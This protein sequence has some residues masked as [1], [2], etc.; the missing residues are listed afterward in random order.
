[1]RIT[2][3]LQWVTTVLCAGAA[4]ALPCHAQRVTPQDVIRA[5][6]AENVAPRS[7]K[8]Y[9]ESLVNRLDPGDDPKIIL[10]VIELQLRA[11]IDLGL[12]DKL[13]HLID[14]ASKLSAITGDAMRAASLEA[15]FARAQFYTGHDIAGVESSASALARQ[16]AIVVDGKH[17]DPTRLFRQ[18]I[19]HAQLIASVMRV[20]TLVT[21]LK[22]AEKLMPAVRNPALASIDHDNLLAQV[23]F[24]L[25]DLGRVR[26][27]LAS[28]LERAKRLEVLTWE[29]EVHFLMAETYIAQAMPA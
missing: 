2:S 24:A 13:Q 6:A 7:Q 9:A 17:P 15:Q 1:M 28:M 11:S 21:T 8:Q 16:E 29:P 27:I 18:L 22:R 10:D 4:L 14:A 25:G 12:A 26:E 23:Y 19:E 20:D 5:E 3:R